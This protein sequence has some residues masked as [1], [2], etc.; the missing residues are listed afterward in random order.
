MEQLAAAHKQYDD[1]LALAKKG[2][3]DAIAKLSG[4]SNTYL[5]LA[6]S[7]YGSSSDYINIFQSVVDQLAKISGTAD[8]NTRMLDIQNQQHQTQKAIYAVLIQIRDNAD[9]NTQATVQAVAA[10]GQS[11]GGNAEVARV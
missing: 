8:Y 1:L 11:S 10:A 2:D 3:V 9:L 7:V 6:R 5:S 4:A